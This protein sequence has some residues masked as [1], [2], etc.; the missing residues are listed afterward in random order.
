MRII[1]VGAGIAGLSTYLLLKKH[2][3]GPTSN[4]NG[5][6][7]ITIYESHNS[8][9]GTADEKGGPNS[10]EELSS[11]T[12]L[13]GGGLSIAP[14]GMRILR[15]IDERLHDEI[16]KRGFVIEHAVF[17]SARGWTLGKIRWGDM[18]EP[19]EF[20]VS[21]ARHRLWECLRD[22]VG[23][24]VIQYRRVAGVETGNTGKPVV[25]FADGS[26]EEAEL[27]IGADGVKSTVRKAIF[28]DKY[29]LSSE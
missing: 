29:P 17:R 9:I 18:R 6:I 10:V 16:T 11:S 24:D 21:I 12:P 28:G 15:E 27:V 26:T 3:L 19:E 2:L 22:A 1:I 14:N 5:H 4:L 25:S 20:S 13:V 8:R 23:E 7:S